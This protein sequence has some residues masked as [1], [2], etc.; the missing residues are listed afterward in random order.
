MSNMPDV[1]KRVLSIMVP[2]EL[3]YQI[4]QEAAEHKLDFS[5]Y[6]RMILSEAMIDVELS[7]EAKA[8]IKKEVEHAKQKRANG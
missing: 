6:V 4:K 1:T 8:K 5:V 2:R 7:S 3:Y